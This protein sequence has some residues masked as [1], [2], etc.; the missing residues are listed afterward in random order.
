MKRGSTFARVACFSERAPD[1]HGQLSRPGTKDE[2][3]RRKSYPSKYT[4]QDESGSRA[5]SDIGNGSDNI[6]VTINC[7]CYSYEIPL[8]Y[9]HNWVE[10]KHCDCIKQPE[11]HF[12]YI[13]LMNT[14]F[15][16]R[17]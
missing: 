4:S 15:E 12:R 3:I 8:F 16:P 9:L 2:G 10:V 5:V 17:N 6:I 11:V 1:G 13:V 7:S 14:Y